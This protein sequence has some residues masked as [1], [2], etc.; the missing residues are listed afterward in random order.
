MQMRLRMPTPSNTD[1]SHHSKALN[2]A[3]PVTIAKITSNKRWLPLR[4]SGSH[5][6]WPGGCPADAEG[7]TL[8]VKSL[9]HLR[10]S[11]HRSSAAR[12]NCHPLPVSCDPRAAR[13]SRRVTPP[14]P[15][16]KCNK[17]L[18]SVERIYVKHILHIVNIC[19]YIFDNLI[20]FVQ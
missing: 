18:G 13:R 17:L 4:L 15:A 6:H 5:S 9:S 7:P 8:K 20:Y 1:V 3:L 16:T 19:I 14:G 11:A 10:S 12:S 2:Q